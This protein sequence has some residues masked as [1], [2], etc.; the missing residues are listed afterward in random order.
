MLHFSC[1]Q[2]KALVEKDLSKLSKDEKLEVSS[3][4]EYLQHIMEQ[5][6][7]MEQSVDTYLPL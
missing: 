3:L 2:E 4:S 7:E 6:Q 5:N 1:V